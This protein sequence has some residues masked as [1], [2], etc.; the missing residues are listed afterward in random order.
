MRY[1]NIEAERARNGMTREKFA[2]SLGVSVST[3]KNWQNG[4][5]EIPASKII[6][7]A[8]LFNVSTDYL[9]GRTANN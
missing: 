8:N 2:T 3:L 9:L 4:K 1:K 7:M 6:V 5:T